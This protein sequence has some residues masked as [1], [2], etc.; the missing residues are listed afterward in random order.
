MS[1]AAAAEKI[2]SAIEVGKREFIMATGMVH[3][4][5]LLSRSGPDAL[6]ELVSGVV[7]AGYAQNI[8]LSGQSLS[9]SAC[10]FVQD[11]EG[12]LRT[13]SSTAYK[14]GWACVG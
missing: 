3:D 13:A 5:A 6:F 11:P 14:V 9:R 7:R 4:M 1:P 10:F 2:L 12:I 8:V